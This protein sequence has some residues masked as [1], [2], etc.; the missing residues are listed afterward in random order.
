MKYFAALPPAIAMPSKMH[1]AYQKVIPLADGFPFSK[2][3]WTEGGE[4]HCSNAFNEFCNHFTYIHF[5]FTNAGTK[6]V[7]PVFGML[8]QHLTDRQT[9]SLLLVLHLQL[10]TSQSPRGPR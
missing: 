1:T 6:S 5:A 2:L 7:L 4:L 9:S 3:L 10:R 8:L